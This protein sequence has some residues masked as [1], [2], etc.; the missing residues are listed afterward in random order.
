LSLS[1]A[2]TQRF[3]RQIALPEVG[4]A[5]QAR[6][7]ESAVA[8]V[9]PAADGS[10]AAEL[11]AEYLLAAG[12][13]RVQAVLPAPSDVGGAHWLDALRGFQ[14]VA[15]FRFDDDALLRATV[16]LGLPVV[17]G[18]AVPDQIEVVSFRRHGPCPH[19]VLDVPPRSQSAAE[20]AATTPLVAGLVATEL[21][22]ILLDPKGGPRARI[23]RLPLAGADQA[24]PPQA[25]DIPWAP[26]C[27]ICGGQSQEAA[28][29]GQAGAETARKTGS[30]T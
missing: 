18:R 6:L 8:L 7:L 5:G 15:R 3:S 28:F 9:R 1:S 11:A 2:Q 10:P 16:R 23:L 21:L 22:G 25:S 14:A 13:G 26:E 4:A 27:F 20:P 19:V 30:E 24:R 29:G 17:F 12:V